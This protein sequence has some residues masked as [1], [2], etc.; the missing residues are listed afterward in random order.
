[1]P[2]VRSPTLIVRRL[3][4]FETS[5]IVTAF[6]RELGKISALAKGLGG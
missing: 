1:M 5:L 3:E 6:S 4:V 2:A